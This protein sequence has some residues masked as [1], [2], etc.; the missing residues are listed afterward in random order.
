[1]QVCGGKGGWGGGGKGLGGGGE[2]GG[3]EGGGGAG[4][5]QYCIRFSPCGVP[6][7]SKLR[8]LERIASLAPFV[9]SRVNSIVSTS[10][11]TMATLLLFCS[12]VSD[13]VPSVF[14]LGLSLPVPNWVE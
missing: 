9:I 6:E 13:A 8:P 2:G 12:G 1:M 4:D 11:Y 5:G 10:M 3:G 14:L 7:N